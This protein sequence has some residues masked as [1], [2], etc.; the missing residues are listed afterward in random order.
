[1]MIDRNLK[2]PDT[3]RSGAIRMCP[4]GFH[5][6]HAATQAEDLFPCL[7][8]SGL[9]KRLIN[10][11]QIWAANRFWMEL[12]N[13]KTKRYGNK[14]RHRWQA[15]LTMMLIFKFCLKITGCYERG[16]RNALDIRL[17]EM[18]LSFP[19]LPKNFHGFT[20]LHLSDLHLDGLEGLAESIVATI[21]DREVDLCVL[22]GDYRTRLHG[23]NRHIMVGL[24][25]LVSNIRSR[26]G[27]IGI[28]GNHDDCHMVNPME[29]MGIRMLIN[30]SCLIERGG[31]RI[32]LIGTDDVHYYYTDQALHCLEAA[33]NEFSIA[34]VHSPELFDLAAAMGVDLYLCGHTHAGQVCLPGGI[35]LLTHLDRGQAYYRGHWRHGDMQ[36]VTNAGAGTSGIPVRFNTRGEILIHH[37]LGESIGTG[38]PESNRPLDQQNEGI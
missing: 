21:G 12:D 34:L 37:L 26:H 4:Q 24:N 16:V 31:E 17:R 20:I 13:M 22:T 8:E 28:L 2:Q 9:E 18:E 23:L 27:F 25:Y 6:A 1:M 32:Q 38:R 30:S 33:E 10:R 15:L 3:A 19:R 5:S 36:G 29:Q 11:R 35:P 14:G 7:M